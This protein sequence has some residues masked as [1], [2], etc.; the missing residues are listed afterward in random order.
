MATIGRALNLCGVLSETKRIINAHSRHFLALSVLFLLPLSFSLIIF[1]TLQSTL[2]FSPHNPHHPHQTLLRHT[3]SHTLNQTLALPL[4]LLYFLLSLSAAVT[5]TYSTY[6]GFYG[7]PVK[8]LSAARTLLSSFLPL[9]A[10]SAAY[11]CLLALVCAAFGAFPFL[12]TK[13]LQTLLGFDEIDYASNPYFLALSGVVLILLVLVL[14]HLKVNWAL[15]SVVVV[16]ESK[17][18]L[19]PLR[20]SAHLMRGMKLV[21]LSLWL[22]FG[23]VIGFFVWAFGSGASDFGDVWSCL[24]F[25]SQTVV[26]S[27]FVTVL[28]LYSV[29]SHAV[30]YM[31]CKALHGELAWEIAEEFAREYVSLPFDEAKV[32]QVVFVAP[33]A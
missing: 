32:P 4:V 2:S 18:G 20:R 24:S 26:G 21:F 6:H 3:Q 7:R 28:M 30:L 19:E 1:P 14:V 9:L 12:V 27:S 8:L 33:Q 23:T 16:V 31:Y 17:W 22:L 13:A 11:H 15:A 29:A 5:I 10:T 25:I